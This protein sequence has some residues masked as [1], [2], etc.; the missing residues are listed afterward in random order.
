MRKCWGFERYNK[1]SPTPSPIA[2]IHLFLTWPQ[3]RACPYKAIVRLLSDT[4]LG[5]PLFVLPQRRSS[6]ACIKLEEVPTK[7][8]N[9]TL[10]L[11]KSTARSQSFDV[12]ASVGW[13]PAPLE[14]RAAKVET[15]S[16]AGQ[17]VV[18]PTALSAAQ[19]VTVASTAAGGI[20]GAIK[21]KNMS[22]LTRPR[23]SVFMS[24]PRAKTNTCPA[25]RAPTTLIDS[26]CDASVVGLPP[27]L[28]STTSLPGTYGHSLAHLDNPRN[29][30]TALSRT[31]SA[32][33]IKD[34]RIVVRARS[35][36]EQRVVSSTPAVVAMGARRRSS[37]ALD[38][39]FGGPPTLQ[40]ASSV[41]ALTLSG[42]GDVFSRSPQLLPAVEGAVMRSYQLSE[43]VQGGGGAGGQRRN[44]VCKVFG[45]PLNRPGRPPLP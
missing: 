40:R 35:Q 43:H 28:V 23:I 36:A 7:V 3:S 1:Q 44:L 31:S 33:R 29:T 6:S 25:M 12:P 15:S 19:T 39:A 17:G 4:F 9:G 2:I 32:N 20:G 11:S 5:F 8:C 45:S 34:L 38:D 18:N 37:P 10:P 16:I 14:I 13:H 24:K 41:G 42:R 27:S 22:A 30:T 21:V 26:S